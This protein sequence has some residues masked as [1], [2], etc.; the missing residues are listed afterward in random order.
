LS[1]WQNQ[2]HRKFPHE[3]DLQLCARALKVVEEMIRVDSQAVPT[4]IDIE[5]RRELLRCMLGRDGDTLLENT[6]IKETKDEQPQRRTR[7]QTPRRRQS[8]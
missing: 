6:E 7:A 2:A 3:I 1:I 8:L 4:D 5:V